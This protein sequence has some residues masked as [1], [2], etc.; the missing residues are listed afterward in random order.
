MLT[1]GPGG[2][3]AAAGGWAPAY[4][5]GP[6]TAARPASRYRIMRQSPSSEG[7]PN[8]AE[9]ADSPAQDQVGAGSEQA[10]VVLERPGLGVEIVTQLRAQDDVLA[11]VEIQAGGQ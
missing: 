9:P 8:P 11:R 4:S 10:V 5:S 1:A 7:K 3:G 6:A 2:A